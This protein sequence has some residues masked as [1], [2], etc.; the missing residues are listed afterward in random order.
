MCG[1]S[2]AP[3]NLMLTD[4][5][6]DSSAIARTR[7]R[8][9][10]GGE[11]GT[12]LFLYLSR[13]LIKGSIQTPTRA[14]HARLI[15]SRSKLW[16]LSPVLSCHTLLAKR[17][18]QVF[19]SKERCKNT[20]RNLKLEHLKTVDQSRETCLFSVYISEIKMFLH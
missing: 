20:K 14:L 6:E 12:L 9:A 10:R 16:L 18:W 2:L 17:L 5:N 1:R 8:E 4:S 15:C 13:P 3:L 7:K 19:K 11:E